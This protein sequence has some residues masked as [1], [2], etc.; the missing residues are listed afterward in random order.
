[1]KAVILDTGCANL[2]SLAFAVKRLGVEP[3]ITREAA[4]IR[5]A[6][7]IFLPGVGTAKAAMTA[8]TE[9]GLPELIREAHQPLLD[10]CL[11]EQLLG[12]RSEETGGVGLLGLIDADVRQ[13]NAPGLP[14]PHMGWNRVFPKFESPQAKLLF[15]NIE[16]GEWF[17]FVHSFAMPDGPAAIASCT[18]GEPFAAAAASE[19][20]MGVQFHPERSGKAGARLLA[21]FLGAAA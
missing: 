9:R 18:Y 12:R 13:L 6:D 3:L 20:F 11:G 5:S 8:L 7:R 10:I 1:M 2:A 17:Y 16:P 19:N 4:D 14:L 21:N 15:K